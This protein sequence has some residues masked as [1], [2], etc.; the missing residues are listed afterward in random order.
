MSLYFIDACQFATL[1]DMTQPNLRHFM[2]PYLMSQK[3]ILLHNLMSVMIVTQKD[4][5][6]I[7]RHFCN[8]DAIFSTL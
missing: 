2:L 8:I 6:A 3:Y 5:V 4:C 7:I 1:V